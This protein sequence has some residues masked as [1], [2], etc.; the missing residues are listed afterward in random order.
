MRLLLKDQTLIRVYT[1][2]HSVY[3]FYVKITFFKFFNNYRNDPKF[4][5]RYVWAN[6][7]DPDQTSLIRVFTGRTCHFIGF[8][9]LRLILSGSQKSKRSKV[10]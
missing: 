7:A 8:V 10:S 5:D 6:S 1:L 2:C 4:S 3:T 9:M